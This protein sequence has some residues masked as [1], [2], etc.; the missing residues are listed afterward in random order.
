MEQKENDF[1]VLK[2]DETPM[3]SSING[4][5]MAV[6][7]LCKNNSNKFHYFTYEILDNE[8]AIIG[9][10]LIYE[11]KDPNQALE[12]WDNFITENLKPSS[13]FTV[14]KQEIFQSKKL[15]F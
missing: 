3:E 11:F 10:K 14:S 2:K 12:E 4:K 15:R 6:S 1:I 5:I 7:Q 8:G 9:G 13:D